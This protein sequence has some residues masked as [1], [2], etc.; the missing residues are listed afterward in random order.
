MYVFSLSTVRVET[1]TPLAIMYRVCSVS[2]IVYR[3]RLRL[4]GMMRAHLTL[5]VKKIKI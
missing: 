5:Y 4:N 1:F 2:D 3:E